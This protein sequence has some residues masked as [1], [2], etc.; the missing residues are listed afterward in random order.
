MMELDFTGH[1]GSR[2]EKTIAAAAHFTKQQLFPR[3]RNVS[4]TFEL[5]KTL[6]SKEGV[7]GDV[8]DDE[9]REFT[10]RVDTSQSE[11]DL[12]ATVIHEMV[13]VYQ[14]VTKRMEQR[15]SH[16]IIFEKRAYSHDVEYCNRPWEIEAHALERDLVALFYKY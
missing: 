6:R 10:I 7:H 3:H 4:V 9:D 11:Q 5:I 13:H 8:M 2:L 12:V 1:K 14:Y 16:E 15:W